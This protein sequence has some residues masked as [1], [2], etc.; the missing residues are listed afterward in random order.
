MLA[1][2]ALLVLFSEKKSRL[3]MKSE[4][5]FFFSFL[6]KSNEFYPIIEFFVRNKMYS[7]I[8]SIMRLAHIFF[9]SV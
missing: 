3:E 5:Q 2:G 7:E 6:G 9:N 4:T 1:Y 8:G